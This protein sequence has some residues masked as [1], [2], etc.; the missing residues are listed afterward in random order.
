MWLGPLLGGAAITL[1]AGVFSGTHGYQAT[2]GVC[3]LAI[4]ASLPFVRR[5]DE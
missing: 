5:L 2:W 1:L 4:L 3:D